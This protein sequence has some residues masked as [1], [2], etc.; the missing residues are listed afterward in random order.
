[1]NHIHSFTAY[2]PETIRIP[3]DAPSKSL[4]FVEFS[5]TFNL[6]A[7]QKTQQGDETFCFVKARTPAF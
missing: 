6:I 4:Y 5:E 3:L 1:M 7:T 2:A